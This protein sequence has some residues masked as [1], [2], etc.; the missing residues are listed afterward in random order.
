M[1]LNFAGNPELA[2][3]IFLKQNKNFNVHKFYKSTKRQLLESELCMT[4]RGGCH[5]LHCQ[6][7]LEIPWSFLKCAHSQTHWAL[8]VSKTLEKYNVATDQC[9]VSCH[10]FA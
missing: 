3:F 4:Q 6:H 9:Y 7:C 10:L 5:L 1:T 8:G 2:P